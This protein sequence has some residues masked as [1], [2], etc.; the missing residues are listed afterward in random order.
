MP[1]TSK[2]RNNS[3]FK[4]IYANAMRIVH[5]RQYDY[6][7][8]DQSTQQEQADFSSATI[9][10]AIQQACDPYSQVSTTS[11]PAESQE[12]SEIFQTVMDPQ[13]RF[14]SQ[15]DISGYRTVVL[16]QQEL[17]QDKH[18]EKMQSIYET[19]ESVVEDARAYYHAQVIVID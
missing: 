9:D 1:W 7:D 17:S 18:F 16:K 8:S 12:F 2:Q 15:V 19:I 10:D 11:V 5:P 3:S 4:H 13:F 6:S 14:S